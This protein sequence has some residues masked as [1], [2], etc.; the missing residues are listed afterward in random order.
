MVEIILQGL[1]SID[2]VALAL[3]VLVFV[4]IQVI[5]YKALS[6]H[7]AL[8]LGQPSRRI[9]LTAFALGGALAAVGLLHVGVL[10]NPEMTGYDQTIAKLGIF[11]LIMGL[12]HSLL[13]AMNYAYEGHGVRLWLLNEL[14]ILM[15]LVVYAVIHSQRYIATLEPGMQTV[16]VFPLAKLLGKVPWLALVIAF[17]FHQALGALWYSK[18][19]FGQIWMQEMGITPEHTQRS[20]GKALALGM[21]FS[22]LAFLLLTVFFAFTVHGWIGGMLVGPPIAMLHATLVGMHCVYEGRSLKAWFIKAVYPGISIA[23]FALLFGLMR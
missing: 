11:V 17:I 1:E 5:W 19:M 2:F 13:S 10:I 7:W 4:S 3:A 21:T 23:A 15:G 16:F 6:K 12:T 9:P 22:A 8:A 14:P 20:F 18:R